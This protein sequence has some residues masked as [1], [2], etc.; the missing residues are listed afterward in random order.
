MNC[1]DFLMAAMNSSSYMV[2]M[3]SSSTSSMNTL[4]YKSQVPNG[5]N[6]GKSKHERVSGWLNVH[7]KYEK[8][9][10]IMEE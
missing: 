4:T 7:T 3:M 9:I 10:E 1:Y 6:L 2:A 8:W 5:A